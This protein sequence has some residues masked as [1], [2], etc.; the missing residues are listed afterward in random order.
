M[1][2]SSLVF[3]F[4]FF[5]LNML[6]YQIPRHIKGK[7]IVMLVF[8][9]VFYAWAGP[10]YLLLLVGMTLWDYCMA[11]GMVHAGETVKRR[12]LFLGL[13]VGG[14]LLLL[15]IFKYLTFIL[16][17]IQFFFGVPDT[18]VQIVLPIGISFYTFQLISYLMDVYRQQVPAQT[19]FPTLLLYV[20]LFHQC[21]AG[22]IVRYETVCHRLTQRHATR[23]EVF[24][25]LRRFVIGLSKKALLANQCGALADQLLAATGSETGAQQLLQQPALAILLGLICY[26]MQIYLDFS[27]YS[28]MAIGMGRMI[29]F[30]YMENFDYPYLSKTVTEFWRRWHMSLSSFF[31]DYLYIPLGGSRRG[32][33]RL[34]LNLLIVWLCTGF[35]HGAAWNYVLWGLYYFVFL[36]I[37]KLFLGKYLEKLPAVFRHIYLLIIVIFGWMLF[38]C[39]NLSW[40]G[41]EL[42]GLFGRNG[43]GFTS[44]ETTAVL[45]SNLFFLIVAVLAC[46]P[47]VKWL[48]GKL[49]KVGETHASAAVIYNCA[50]IVLP[51]LLLILSTA[52][53]V[54]DSYNPFL[55]TQF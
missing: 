28:D 36:V 23:T 30:H 16:T 12:K 20:S 42:K 4:F 9:L 7:N 41:I 40:V 18:V 31:R 39:E 38:R 22:P 1:V 37:E 14:N 10:V 35:W 46:T 27:A 29:G 49:A 54:G 32:T 44:F 25:G 26:T 50:M 52:S 47:I 2:F 8:S 51:V 21:V 15:C 43:N 45:K 19:S 5:P 33:A 13:G 48:K 17:N 53:L 55:Y 6:C 24:E 34:V 3:C 11:L